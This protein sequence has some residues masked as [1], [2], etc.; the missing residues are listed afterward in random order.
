MTDL[1]HEQLKRNCA[2]ALEA[3][4]KEQRLDGVARLAD[5]IRTLSPDVPRPW[6]TDPSS[7]VG[8]RGQHGDVA[9][10]PRA[11]EAGE[12]HD[13]E[14]IALNQPSESPRDMQC[15]ESRFQCAW[16]S[17]SLRS[18]QGCICWMVTSTRI[19]VATTYHRVQRT[20]EAACWDEPVAAAITASRNWASSRFNRVSCSERSVA[21]ATSISALAASGP[22]LPPALAR[23]S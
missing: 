3:L 8:P 11:R 22:A 13:E 7:R 23:I 10:D 9:S 14:Y 15:S 21:S 6:G 18:L 5:S 19:N 12:G 16:R 1:D 17:E 4:T 2:D 20:S